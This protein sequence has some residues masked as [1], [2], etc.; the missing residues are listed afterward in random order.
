MFTCEVVRYKRQGGLRH[1]QTELLAATGQ[2]HARHREVVVV[3]RHRHQQVQQ[4]LP[5]VLVHYPSAT[6]EGLSKA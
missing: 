1:T 5:A 4:Q 2:Q 3:R 6:N